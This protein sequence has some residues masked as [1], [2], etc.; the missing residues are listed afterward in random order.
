MGTKYTVQ[1][2]VSDK[3]DDQGAIGATID[4]NV[5]TRAFTLQ[6]KLPA[7][8]VE[9]VVSSA[10]STLVNALSKKGTLFEKEGD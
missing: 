9:E 10:M 4:K 3:P 6:E 8:A 1:V 5:K 7:E 2:S